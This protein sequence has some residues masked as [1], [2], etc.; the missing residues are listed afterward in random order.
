V[1]GLQA[2]LDAKMAASASVPWSQITGAPTLFSGAFSSL[3]GVPNTLAGYGITDA[4]PSGRTVNG[5]ALTGNVTITT[6]S[7]NAGTVTTNA[8]LTGP[9]TSAGNA[10]AIADGALSEAK[11][12]GLVSDLAG[13][14][15]LASPALTGVPTAP[16][17][18]AATNTTQVA[19]TAFVLANGSGGSSLV[20]GTGTLTGYSVAPVAATS[21]SGIIAVSGGGVDGDTITA[22]V[23]GIAYTVTQNSSG[24]DT[25]G[26]YSADTSPLI[27]NAF[28]FLFS[29]GAP[30]MP[31]PADLGGSVQI[32]S[33]TVGSASTL[34]F[35]AS[36]TL[37]ITFN[38]LVEGADAIPGSGNISEVELIPAVAG[39]KILSVWIS[40]SG[41]ISA[42]VEIDLKHA[43]VYTKITSNAGLGYC[44]MPPFPGCEAPYLNGHDAGESLVARSTSAPSTGGTANYSAIV[45]QR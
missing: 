9:V 24:G 13:K 2:A 12:S 3:T 14:A 1:T 18:A 27:A 41:G 7:G 22:T 29:A 11:T 30:P 26:T 23:D 36:N 31:T 4:V 17:A 37:N 38:S 45:E 5:Q 20:R 39:K 44:L 19:T 33:T 6:I 8:N 42:T 10:T 34:N 43:G 15:P 21:A 35:A 16:T 25:G 32:N 40:E 28:G